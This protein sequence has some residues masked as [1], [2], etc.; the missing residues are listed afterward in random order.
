MRDHDRDNKP[1][2]ERD[3]ALIRAFGTWGLTAAIVNVTIGAGI[4]RLPSSVAASLGAAAPAAYV[5][6][7][8]AMGLIVL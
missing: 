7:T 4:F 6:C 3:G 2:V 8:V 1:E 5:V